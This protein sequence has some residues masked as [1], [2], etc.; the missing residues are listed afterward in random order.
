MLKVAVLVD[1]SYFLKRY[2][3]CY[4]SSV[5]SDH[6]PSE[7]A[8]ALQKMCN[9]HVDNDYLY[10]VLYYDCPP[11]DNRGHNPISRKSIDFSKTKEFA[12]RTQL[13]EELKKKRKFALRLGEVHTNWEWKLRHPTLKALMKGDIGLDDLT[14]ND[15]ELV[16]RQKGVD[17]KI[18]VDISALAYKKLVDKI[19]L[20]AGD[21]DFVPAAKVARR[22]GIDFVLDPMWNHIHPSLFEHIDGLKS[23]CPQPKGWKKT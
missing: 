9:R 2:R 11:F 10:R 6:L 22:E 15:V 3:I 1:G 8:E 16:M 18:A 21:S 12:F 13:L 23:V 19:I 14:E 5:G 7:V 20:I 4:K 17:L